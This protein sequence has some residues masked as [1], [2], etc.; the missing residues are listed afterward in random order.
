MKLLIKIALM[1][2][3]ASQT[4]GGADIKPEPNRLEIYLPREVMVTGDII[5]LGQ[6]GIVRGAPSLVTKAEEVAM[7]RFSVAGQKI[8]V[9]RQTISSRL[10]SSDIDSSKVVLLGA[11]EVVV[12]RQETLI[13]GAELI[14]QAFTFLK[15]CDAYRSADRCTVVKPPKDIV[16]ESKREN[17]RFS[18]RLAGKMGDNPA[19]VEVIIF[20]GDKGVAKSEVTLRLKYNKRIAVTTAQIKQ[21]E[22]IGE[23]NAR[24]MQGSS[25]SPEP[26]DWRP[27]YG[28]RATRSL[29]KGVVVGSDAVKAQ[30]TVVGVSR[31]QNVVIK[32]NRPGL[33]VT[34]TGKAMQ[35]GK[36]GEWI[37]VQNVDSNR[38]IIAKI[39][40]DGTVEPVF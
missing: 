38:V 29:A 13:S 30:E 9:D 6:I 12:Q 7:G 37:K 27:P 40:E 39:N 22:L 31:N 28:R 21:G 36:A 5:R 4:A 1:C 34:T 11:E 25:D 18:P 14:E 32:V 33:V 24:I 3:L 17:I 16:I 19:D 23:D 26:N 20:C 2:L 15:R 10:A 35:N 8:T